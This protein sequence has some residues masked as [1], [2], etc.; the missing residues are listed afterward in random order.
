LLTDLEAGAINMA[1]FL[2]VLS[3]SCGAAVPEKV[4]AE[5]YAGPS[6]IPDPL[7]ALL[8]ELKTRLKLGLIAN[9][10]PWQE[11]QIIRSSRDLACF[12]AMTLSREAK[13]RLPNHR[14][15]DNLLEK[16]GLMSEECLF[17]TSRK[18]LA[19]AAELQLLHGHAFKDPNTLRVRVE[20]PSPL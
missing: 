5:A 2:E 11:A 1:T 15:F 16:L 6:A 14:I 4:L 10:N 17:V 19:E 13:S 12:D 7:Q 9:A 8:L 18:D 20:K 3:G